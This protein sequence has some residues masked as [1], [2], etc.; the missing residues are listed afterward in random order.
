M[1]RP[2]ILWSFILCLFTVSGF[3]QAQEVSRQPDS[4][5]L[6]SYFT[7]K[8]ANRHGMHYA[9]SADGYVW[10]TIGAPLGFLQPDTASD[11]PRLRD[12]FL[13]QDKKGIWHCVWTTNWEAPHIGYASSPDLIH[14][15]E[16]RL[17]YVMQSAGYEPRNCWAPEM[18]YDEENK[19]IWCG[20]G[21]NYIIMSAGLENVDKTLYEAAKIDGCNSWKRFLHVTLPGIRPQLFL[22][23]FTTLI[24]Y[25]NIYG[26]IFI[27]GS[28]NPDLDSMKSAVYRIQDLLA[29]S[30][31]RAFGYAAAMGILLGLIIIVIAIVQLIV[32]RDRKG[33][34]KH[35][36]GFRQ[37]KESK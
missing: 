22:T 35:A 6:F 31:P 5:Y 34:T 2:V 8:D 1:K 9:W 36:E 27:L 26:Q 32:T 4:L 11:A 23:L 7:N 29:G 37:W 17:L 18:L 12:P 20:I 14:W 16:P 24:G 30:N 15:S 33:G 25:M 13:L 10:N 21:G 3:A 19:A 28:N